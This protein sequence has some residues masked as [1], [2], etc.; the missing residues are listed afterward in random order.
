MEDGL[1]GGGTML[2]EPVHFENPP[3]A[4]VAMGLLFPPLQK[5][6]GPH[7][8]VLWDRWKSDFTQFGEAPPLSPT[9]ELKQGSASPSIQLSISNLPPLPRTWYLSKDGQKL[10]QVQRDRYV[11]NWRKADAQTVYPQYHATFV[12]FMQR[13]VEFRGFLAEYELG[14]AEAIQYEL[15]YVDHIAADASEA[16]VSPTQLARRVF[17]DVA[18]RAPGRG[19]MVDPEGFEHRLIFG[20]PEELGRAHIRIQS[21]IRAESGQ[22]LII[23]ESVARGFGKAAGDEAMKEWFAMAHESLI[24]VFLGLTSHEV[25]KQWW[26]RA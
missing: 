15:I 23:M 24:S 10:I 18:F 14:S 2:A 3:V 22:P 26:G 6:T 7:L 8:G 12:Q 5:L 19:R 1:C 21:A 9:I 4:E 11:Y 20:L 13:L 16:A 17:P 25:Q